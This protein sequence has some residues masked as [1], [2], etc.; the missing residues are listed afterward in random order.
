MGDVVV[1]EGDRCDDHGDVV[2]DAR[3]LL[4]R[5]RG[6][7]SRTLGSSWAFCEVRL[8][9]ELVWCLLVECCDRV[10]S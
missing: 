9:C 1:G 2:R 6:R 4:G 8:L 7:R 10:S 5:S 3:M